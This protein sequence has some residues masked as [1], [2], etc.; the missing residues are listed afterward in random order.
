LIKLNKLNETNRTLRKYVVFFLSIIMGLTFIIVIALFLYGYY[1]PS[2]QLKTSLI[3]ENATILRS[4]IVQKQDNIVAIS[5]NINSLLKSTISK[6]NKTELINNIIETSDDIEGVFILDKNKV[7]LD[8][9]PQIENIRGI[10]HL[11]NL[12]HSINTNENG[13]F[14]R[15][16]FDYILNRQV[17]YF[18]FEIEDSFV[19]VA[20]DIQVQN[21]I[22]DYRL[23]KDTYQ[24]HI[25]DE[26]NRIVYSSEGNFVMYKSRI[27]D[28]QQIPDEETSITLKVIENF[29]GLRFISLDLLIPKSKWTLRVTVPEHYIHG[30]F[31]SN[32]I[33]PLSFIILAFASLFSSY[34]LIHS[35]IVLP[36]ER[37]RRN[38]ELVIQ[39]KI[40]NIAPIESNI[41]ILYDLNISFTLM[42]K[43]IREREKNLEEFA[44]IAS[45]VL[46]KPLH[47]IE[48][49]LNSI[50]IE[51]E[52]SLDKEPVKF[53]KYATDGS[54]RMRVLIDDLLAYS[55]SGRIVL[56]QSVSLNAVLEDVLYILQYEIDDSQ[57]K[58]EIANLPNVTGNYNSLLQVFQNMIA[59]SI[60]FCDEMPEIKIW[61]EDNKIF[62]KDN[63]IGIESKYADTIFEAFKRLHDSEKYSGTGIGLTIV[64]KIVEKHG[65]NIQLSTNINSGT[66]F[67][68]VFEIDIEKE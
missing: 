57:A 66:V 45:N 11:S 37:L 61:Y 28:E 38:L 16:Q 56:D 32:T 39:N 8:S 30:T 65:W 46:Q 2:V 63:G 53:I 52:D 13:Y 27:L 42:N 35:Y 14:T 40:Q 15:S 5:N 43:A 49:A 18:I 22:D 58:F 50:E 21:L 9:Y 3:L 24:T 36:L 7:L 41:K 1:L 48:R 10:I 62:I 34:R 26:H 23:G 44:C 25:I 59:N 12:I 17:T 60:K 51:L 4:T 54:E 6:K 68:T 55:K 67:G 33:L 47:T 31:F 20:H 64:K 19:A 29:E